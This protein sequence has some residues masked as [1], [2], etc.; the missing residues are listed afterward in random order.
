M[1]VY[2]EIFHDSGSTSIVEVLF[3]VK[4]SFRLQCC[5]AN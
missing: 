5:L 1:E 3:D 4:C 2:I